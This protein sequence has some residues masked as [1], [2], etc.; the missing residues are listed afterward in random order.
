MRQDDVLEILG[1][2][3][4]AG[5]EVWVA[6]GWGVD[7]LVGRQTRP[8]AD[9]DLLHRGEQEPALLAALAEAGFAE[10][11]DWRPARF[12]VTD[13]RGR[14]VDLHPLAVA[15]D[16]SATQESLEPGT[17][18]RYPASCF[19]TGTIG[20]TAVGCLSVEQQILFH[21]GYEPA[22]RDR[23]DMAVLHEAFGVDTPL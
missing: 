8:H 16:G 20:G 23:L 19:V 17:P 9:L 7:P 6:G 2:V 1:L 13:G 3:R 14:E 22:E 11:L 10:T 12:V 5:A 4:A 21:Q 15:A 18:Y